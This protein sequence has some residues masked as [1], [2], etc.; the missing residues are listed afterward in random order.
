[1]TKR[2]CWKKGMRL[3]DEILRMSDKCHLESLAKTVIIAANG[4]FGLLPSKGKFNISVSI[5]K[6]I[7]D[8]EALSCLAI[9]KSGAIVDI[10][11]DTRFANNMETR[12]SIPSVDAESYILSVVVLDS[13]KESYNGLCEPEYKFVLI[14]ENT[15]LEENMMPIARLINEYGWR[16]DEINF[17]PPCLYVMSHPE[18]ILLADRF[19]NILNLSSS[20]LLNSVNSDC[21][22]A[23]S[24]FLPIVEQ[25]RIT[26]DK[27]LELMTPMQLFGNVQK[28]ISGFLCACTMDVVLD[29]AEADV[30][31]NYI[32][33]PYNYKNVYLRIK[34]GLE[35][36]NS[37][38]EK[39]EKFKDFKPVETKI[40]APTI[41]KDHLFKKC[42]NSKV[43]IPIENNCSDATVYYTIDG[44]EP[45]SMSSTGSMIIF[46]SGFTGGRDKEEDDRI[47]VVKLKAILNGV[48]SVTN[49]FKIKLQKDVKHWIEI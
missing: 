8:V 15:N 28:Y 19:A 1:M 35:H 6:N 46:S 36:C 22:T 4:R 40:E 24:L 41:S 12:V 42:T 5:N 43:R 23:I 10:D 27:D 13:W 2:I 34:E 26:L 38:C 45:T 30:Y 18:Y 44:T 39:L 47:V 7:V 49:T 29:L 20:H 14:Q 32:S 33:S 37:I 9:T 17:L 16:T 31:W 25:L 48:S 3:T 21:K 11:Y